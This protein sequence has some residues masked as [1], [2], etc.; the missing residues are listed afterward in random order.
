[1]LL[2]IHPKRSLRAPRAP[3]PRAP[4]MPRLFGGQCASGRAGKACSLCDVGF[5]GGPQT[6]R[7]SSGHKQ[8]LPGNVTGRFGTLIEINMGGDRGPLK[9]LLSSLWELAVF[10]G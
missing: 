5:V 10:F 1:M 2:C 9:R 6:T 7:W 4:F 8:E 3:T